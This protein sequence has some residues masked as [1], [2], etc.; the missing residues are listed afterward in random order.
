MYYRHVAFK[1]LLESKLLATLRALVWLDSLVH[2]RDVP[3]KAL[4][5]GELPAELLPAFFADVRF[6]FIVNCS[7]VPLKGRL[8][9]IL[10]LT[11]SA[12]V[13]S[14]RYQNAFKRMYSACPLD[15]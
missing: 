15:M 10:I 3:T 11:L 1:I 4:I 7:Q 9:P 14:K 5:K 8:S 12:L 6:H 13:T 2:F